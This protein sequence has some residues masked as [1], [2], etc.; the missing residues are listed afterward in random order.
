MNL[1][2]QAAAARLAMCNDIGEAAYVPSLVAAELLRTLAGLPGGGEAVRAVE[3]RYGVEAAG[4]LV[5]CTRGLRLTAAAAA[6]TGSSSAS[7]PALPPLHCQPAL[8]PGCVCSP[9]ASMAPASYP[10]R[11]PFYRVDG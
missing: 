2:N 6:A 1:K 10:P 7:R 8:R 4:E 9:I 11:P 3:K 5:D